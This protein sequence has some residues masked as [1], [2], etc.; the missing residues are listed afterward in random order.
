MIMENGIDL[1][2]PV[3]IL[4]GMQDP[5]VPWQ[6]A[7]KLVDALKSDNVTLNLNKS[8]DHRLSEPDDIERLVTTVET[9][10]QQV[11]GQDASE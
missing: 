1:D 7:L 8:G 3:R 11:S 9:L 10:C 6:H 2:C 4:Q 5:D